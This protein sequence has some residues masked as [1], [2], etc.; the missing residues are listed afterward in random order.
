MDEEELHY[1]LRWAQEL[2]NLWAKISTMALERVICLVSGGIDSPV[3]AMLAAK[4]FEIIPLHFCLY[5]YTS[6]ENFFTA[7]EVLKTL[8]EKTGFE[9]AVL[10]P[11]SKILR[12][13]LK[14]SG[15]YSC[16][17]CR[18]GMLM[19]AELLCERE[20]AAGIVT[21]ESIG[22]KASQTIQNLAATSSGLKFPV[23]RPLLCHDKVEVVRLSREL[24]LWREVHAGCCYAVPK[25]PST[26]ASADI[27]STLCEKIGL[28][29]IIAAEM[30]NVLEL[31][32]F[33][34]D[35][36]RFLASFA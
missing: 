30:G 6:K 18:K 15:K 2:L 1:N 3:A 11:W 14:P 13:I 20:G 35:V 21:G 36:K 28:R 33:T 8:K 19:V 9:K 27:I 31:R 23:L 29:A 12:K 4:S 10:F 24:G 7:V 22:Q 16:V 5:P 26:M 17:L 34:K 25:R 32:D